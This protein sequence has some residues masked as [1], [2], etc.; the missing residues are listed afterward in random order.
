MSQAVVHNGLLYSS[1]QVDTEASDVTEQTRNILR[2]ID[3]VLAEAGTTRSRII[4]ANI[5]LADITSFDAM[6]VVWEEWIDRTAPPARA[7]VESRLAS[8]QYKVEISI[9]AAMP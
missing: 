3:R 2:K 8:P 1:G 7:T 6:N 4:S 5:W 9:I